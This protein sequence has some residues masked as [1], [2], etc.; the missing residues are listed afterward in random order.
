MPVWSPRLLEPADVVRAAMRL[1][2]SAFVDEYGDAP[3]LAIHLP[4]SE[5]GMA[6]ALLAAHQPD[7]GTRKALQPI[8]FHTQMA[9]VAASNTPV[10][11]KISTVGAASELTLGS[12]TKVLGERCYLSAVRRRREGPL[13]NRVSIGRAMNQD[14]V[15]RHASISKFHAYLQ[16][17]EDDVWTVSDGGSKNGT[18]VN[19]VRLGKEPRPLANGERLTFGSIDAVFID[20]PTVWRL[21]RAT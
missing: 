5:E 10:A 18:S 13:G 6:A 4:A 3:W 1:A 2:E 7:T 12:I 16:S 17:T 20:T 19:G 8:E 15:L 9:S 14:I 11:K 21:L